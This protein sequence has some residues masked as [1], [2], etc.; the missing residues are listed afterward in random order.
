LVQKKRAFKQAEK[1]W[2]DENAKDIGYIT[3]AS[4]DSD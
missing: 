4:E 3:P 1:A 2:R